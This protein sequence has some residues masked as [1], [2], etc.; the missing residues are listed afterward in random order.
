MPISLNREIFQ[1]EKEAQTIVK[2]WRLRYNNLLHQGDR[3]KIKS[4]EEPGS[5]INQVV[6]LRGIFH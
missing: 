2:A 6:E 3:E 5:A 4:E 1:S